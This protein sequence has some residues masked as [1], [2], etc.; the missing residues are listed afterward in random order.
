MLCRKL[1][2]IGKPIRKYKGSAVGNS[3]S[4]TEINAVKLNEHSLSDIQDVS[5]YS[6][7]YVIRVPGG[8]EKEIGVKIIFEEIIVPK[9]MNSQIQKLT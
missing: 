7:I 8:Q 1:D 9:Y 5:K 4:E 3:Q 6:H 2:I